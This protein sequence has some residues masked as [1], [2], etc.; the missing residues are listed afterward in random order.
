MA[1]VT[2]GSFP[3][4]DFSGRARDAA[5]R[6]QARIAKH[7]CSVDLTRDATLGLHHDVM[8]SRTVSGFESL[9]QI[10]LFMSIAE[11]LCQ[12]QKLHP[13]GVQYL[14]APEP[15]PEQDLT[16]VAVEPGLVGAIV[17]PCM[18]VGVGRQVAGAVRRLAK[19]NLKH[20]YVF[21]VPLLGRRE[22]EGRVE[23]YERGGVQVWSMHA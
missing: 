7:T 16:I 17:L 4:S 19:R 6:F 8:M 9:R 5:R 1:I 20:R 18:G 12:L 14:V 15:E 21:F 3:E 22:A 2:S 23:K 11:A 13:G 10:T